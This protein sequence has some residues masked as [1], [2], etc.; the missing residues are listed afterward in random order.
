MTRELVLPNLPFILVYDTAGD[1]IASCA[2]C[3]A[4][5]TGRENRLSVTPTCNEKWF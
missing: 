5:R 2:C 4:R 3:I 1:A